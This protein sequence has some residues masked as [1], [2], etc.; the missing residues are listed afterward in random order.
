MS[1]GGVWHLHEAEEAALYGSQPGYVKIKDITGD[2]LVTT[3]DRQILGQKDP[4]FMWGM[5]NSWSYKSL[6]LTVFMHGVHGITKELDLINDQVSAGV[7]RNTTWKNWWTPE[8]PTND[9]YKNTFDASHQNGIYGRIFEKADFIRIKD[10]TLSYDLAN[11]ILKRIGFSKAQIYATGRNL[12]TITK[13]RGLDP[14]LDGQTD[15]PLQKEYVF[16]LN[17]KL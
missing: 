4:K 16:G 5:S 8:N 1:G 11:N 3:D 10:I 17:L 13:W 7:T 12:F 14:E 6:T 15:I 9:W 2:T